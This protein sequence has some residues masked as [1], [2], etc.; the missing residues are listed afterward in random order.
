MLCAHG[1]CVC[2]RVCVCVCRFPGSQL[3]SSLE[4]DVPALRQCTQQVLTEMGAPSASIPVRHAANTPMH[5]S[6]HSHGS[7]TWTRLML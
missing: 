2:V 3:S 7:A 6:T 4:E 1:M 5:S